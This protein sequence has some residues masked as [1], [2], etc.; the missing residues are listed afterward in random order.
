MS[1]ENQEKKQLH[2]IFK[3]CAEMYKC[4]HS[5]PKNW[6]VPPTKLGTLNFVVCKHLNFGGM[7][8]LA[9][10]IE[11][12]CNYVGSELEGSHGELEIKLSRH[13]TGERKLPI[14]EWA[15]NSAHQLKVVLTQMWKSSA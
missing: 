2:K 11:F 10:F 5:T 9:L 13:T 12:E 4:W 7:Q 14:F 8:I 15:P 1:S 3:N 6:N